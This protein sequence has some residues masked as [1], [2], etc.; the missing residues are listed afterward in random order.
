MTISNLLASAITEATSDNTVLSDGAVATLMLI[1]SGEV[2][3]Q[4]KNSTG[5]YV[6]MGTL[7]NDK[8]V[9]QVFGPV[10]F[11]VYRR[12]VPLAWSPDGTVPVAPIVGVDMDKA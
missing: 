3:V 1:G 7:N 2:L 10:T 12:K 4:A 6:L 8:P 5:G 9:Q 11:R